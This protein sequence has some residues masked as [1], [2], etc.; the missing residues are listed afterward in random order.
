[1][2]KK[3]GS[4]KAAA[5]CRIL[6]RENRALRKQVK[7]LQARLDGSEQAQKD[8]R[9]LLKFNEKNSY[10]D[11]IA[12]R[13][14]SEMLTRSDNYLVYLYKTVK[15]SS[16]YGIFDRLVMYFRRIK[17]IGTVVNIITF[18]LTLLR[19]GTIIIVYGVLILLFVPI[20]LLIAALVP[21]VSMI[22]SP[23]S[24]KL[25]RE[26]LANKDVY[27]FNPSRSSGFETSAFFSSN[28]KSLAELENSAVIVVSPYFIKSTPKAVRKNINIAIDQSTPNI[29]YVRRYYYFA[30]FKKVL[31]ND[32]KE[33]FY[34]Y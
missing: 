29:Y 30:L 16:V 25:M 12:E 27:V 33:L 11:N 28:T 2:K 1:M 17:L 34:I 19:T 26:Y 20:T 24:H 3:Q 14:N 15:L 7:S 10:C 5:E 18:I 13:K 4:R 21:M 22:L 23:K 6:K 8:I 32:C 9:S 31:K